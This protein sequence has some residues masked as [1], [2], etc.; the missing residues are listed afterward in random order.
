M[1]PEKKKGQPHKCIHQF[2]GPQPKLVKEN[3]SVGG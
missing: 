2:A 1:F 3:I